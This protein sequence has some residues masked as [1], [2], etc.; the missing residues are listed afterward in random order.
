MLLRK[1]FSQSFS[2]LFLDGEV[3]NVRTYS[4]TKV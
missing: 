4:D 1:G 3:I 2:S